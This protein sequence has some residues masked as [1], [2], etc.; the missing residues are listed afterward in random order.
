MEVASVTGLDRT[1]KGRAYLLL[2]VIQVILAVLF[3]IV[4]ILF[5]AATIYA[6]THDPQNIL[7]SLGILVGLLILYL[8]LRVPII[9]SIS[10]DTLKT[11]GFVGKRSLDLSTLT[12]ASMTTVMVGGRLGSL[13]Q[14]SALKLSSQNG[15]G[16]IIALGAIPRSKRV[17]L[18]QLL[19]PYL[20]ASGVTRQDGVTDLLQKW[21]P[22]QSSHMSATSNQLVASS[23]E[24]S[25]PTNSPTQPPSLP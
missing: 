1:A 14:H 13:N 4:L 2:I 22:G 19:Q 3:L 20:N 24:V 7:F 17:R 21:L 18:Y 5:I 10:E 12:R 6:I 25:N 16:V 23:D 11:Y 9:T 15:K 8:P